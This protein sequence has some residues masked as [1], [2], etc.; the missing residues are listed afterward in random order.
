[1]A[2]KGALGA[3]IA[4]IIIAGIGFSYPVNNQGWTIPRVNDLCT[5]GFGQLG[6]FF[7]GDIQQGCNEFRYLTYVVYGSGLIGI[8]LLIVGAVVS[9]Q[10]QRDSQVYHEKTYK[11]RKEW[12]C[13]YCKFKTNGGEE[14]IEHYKV[15]HPKAKTDSLHRKIAKKPISNENLEILKRRYAQ[16]EITKDEF[17]KIKQDLENS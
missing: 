5:S 10:N 14:L 6:Q 11:N 2:N 12:S 7:I 15:L 4:L 1:M 8:V 9:S 17:D 3:G 13:E 16:G